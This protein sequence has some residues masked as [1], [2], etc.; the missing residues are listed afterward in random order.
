MFLRFKQTVKIV[1]ISEQLPLSSKILMCFDV[2]DAAGVSDEGTQ[3][4]IDVWIP[5]TKGVAQDIQ[6]QYLPLYERCYV[7][8]FEY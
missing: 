7:E 5:A 1:F 8:F 4:R 6:R 2:A 3:A